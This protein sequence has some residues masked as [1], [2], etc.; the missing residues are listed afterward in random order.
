MLPYCFGVQKETESKTT[1]IIKTKNG[2]LM[3]PSKCSMCGSKE[4]IFIK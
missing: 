4:L 1:K 3:F 2:R